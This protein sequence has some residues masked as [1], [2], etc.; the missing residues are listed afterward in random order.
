MPGHLALTVTTA[1]ATRDE[2]DRIARTLVERR[3]AACVQRVGPI[4]STYRWQGDIE[5]AEEWLL[6]IKT[7]AKLLP[8]LEAA[9][10]ELHSYNV[11]E[12]LALPVSGGS[13]AYLSWLLESTQ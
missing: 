10:V 6:I 5:T 4:A 11:P 12:I 2:A 3:L 1:C 9:I 13:P 8:E 7:R